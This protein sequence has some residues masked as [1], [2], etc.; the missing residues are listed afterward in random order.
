MLLTFERPHAHAS[1]E[2]L[3]RLVHEAMTLANIDRSVFRPHSIQSAS[4]SAAKKGGA[5]FSTLWTQRAGP[6]PRPSLN[7]IANQSKNVKISLQQYLTTINLCISCH[8]LG[9]IALRHIFWNKLVISP[10]TCV[11]NFVFTCVP[12]W[13]MTAL[14]SSRKSSWDQEVRQNF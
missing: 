8:V 5:V 11:L 1:K 6:G 9:W 4:T 10:K 3:P 2:T 13:N 7:I 12:H 14:N